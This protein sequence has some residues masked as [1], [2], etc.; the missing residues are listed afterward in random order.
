MYRIFHV[1]VI[2]NLVTFHNIA[3]NFTHNT[4]VNLNFAYVM[5]EHNQII[6]KMCDNVLSL[7]KYQTDQSNL[8]IIYKKLIKLFCDL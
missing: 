4:V 2:I 1:V 7:Q 8:L 5:K 6:N 3:I